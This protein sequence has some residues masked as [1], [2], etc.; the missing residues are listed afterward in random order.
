[1]RGDLEER[2]HAAIATNSVNVA[3]LERLP[4]LDLP[5]GW[6]VAGCLFQAVWNAEA[7]RAP[8]ENVNDYDV[9]YFDAV[10][11]SY[12]A[13][14]AVIRRVA[15]STDDLGVKVEVKNQARVHLWY[16]QRFGAGYPQ[17]RSSQDGID[18]FLIAG[19][20]VALG[21]SPSNAGEL[22]APFGLDDI[23]T[24]VLRP[25]IN[26]LRGDRY[27]D[28]AQSYQARWPHL[29]IMPKVWQQ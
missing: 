9:F 3:L 28:K 8:G 17:L 15:A 20:C 14:D 16:A 26:N 22:Y 2:F 6:L 4:A 27:A 11:L 10:D 1:V 12:E 19:T 18:R 5:D 24:G 23:F 25:N 7:G 13:E 29:T 21:A